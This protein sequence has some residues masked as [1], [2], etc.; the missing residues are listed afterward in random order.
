M[1][2][3]GLRLQLLDRASD[4]ARVIQRVV[5][6]RAYGQVCEGRKAEVAAEELRA[7][8]LAADPPRQSPLRIAQARLG[9]R[10]LMRLCQSL[11]G[12]LQRAIVLERL[13]DDAV[14]HLRAEQR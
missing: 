5:D 11:R 13:L 4:A 7:V 1:R 6:G 8:L 14:D 2:R 12:S 3:L 9:A 10:E